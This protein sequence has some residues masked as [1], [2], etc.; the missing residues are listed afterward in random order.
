MQC[1]F[2]EYGAEGIVSTNGDVYS[3]GIILLEIFTKKKPTDDMFEGGLN[4][5]DWVMESIEKKTVMEVVDRSLNFPAMEEFLYSI[6]GLA[7]DCL[8]DLPKKRCNMRD[9]VA[10][11]QKIKTAFMKI[12]V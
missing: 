7:M 9:V 2:V 4:L 6:F 1:C 5:K 11:L 8:A 12:S 3:Y 10:A